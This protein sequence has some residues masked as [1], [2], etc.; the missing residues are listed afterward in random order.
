M[1][2]A[3]HTAG[4]A[5]CSFLLF[6]APTPAMYTPNPAGRWAPNRFTL[7]GDFQFNADKD[8]D[9]G[10]GSTTLNDTAGFL[11]GTN[12]DPSPQVRLDAQMRVGNETG[13]FFSAAYT[14]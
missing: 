5:V 14:F 12:F 1:P 6:S 8:L 10:S 2:R 13:F 3:L 4:L 7:A 11:F 9:A